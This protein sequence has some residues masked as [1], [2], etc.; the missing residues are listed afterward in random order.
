MLLA[1]YNMSRL[2]ERLVKA[3]YI[4]REDCVDDGRGQVL[5]ITEGGSNLLRRMWP[6]YREAIATHFAGRLDAD[7]TAMLARTLA[8]LR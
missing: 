5:K 6:A 1:Q 8:K 3:G 7:E 4:E 2:T